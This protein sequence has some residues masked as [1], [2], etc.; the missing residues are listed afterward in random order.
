MFIVAVHMAKKRKI[1]I[2]LLMMEVILSA[3]VMVSLIG[4]MLFLQ[5]SALI[6]KTFNGSDCYYFSPRSYY[7]PD[8]RIENYLSDEE[9]DCVDLGTTHILSVKTDQNRSVKVIGY[10]D[11]IIERAR[12]KIEAG[13]W[14]TDVDCN[15]VPLIAIGDTYQIGKHVTFSNGCEGTVIGTIDKELMSYLL[16]HQGAREMHRCQILFRFRPRLI[17]SLRMG[18][19][20]IYH[21][22]PK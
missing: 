12:L 9:R 5:K 7:D 19:S 8:F 1:S 20:S 3:V 4:Q 2:L 15:T 14:F 17:L 13:G 16:C 21:C 10:S 22:P 6:V 11:F 18:V